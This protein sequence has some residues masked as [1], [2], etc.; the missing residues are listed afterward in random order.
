[1]LCFLKQ[2][3]KRTKKSPHAQLQ[4]RLFGLQSVDSPLA[5]DQHSDLASTIPEDKPVDIIFVH[6][7]GGSARGTWT[8]PGTKQFWPEWL[9]QLNSMRNVRIYTFGYDS[10]WEKLWAP[11]NYLGIQG[12]AEQLVDSLILHYEENGD[13]RPSS[14]A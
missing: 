8:H 6:G 2:R 10:A 12:F 1:M 3:R 7:L 11:R 13:V 14:A 9:F 4:E 5:S